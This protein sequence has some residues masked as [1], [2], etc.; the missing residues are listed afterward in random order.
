MRASGRSL[1]HIPRVVQY[2]F[3]GIFT[4]AGLGWERA[5][6]ETNPA[7]PPNI[8]L[9]TLCSVR[10]D[11]MSCYGYRRETTPSLDALAKESIVFENALSQWPL[12]V[13]FFASLITGK[14]PHTTGIVVRIHN[15]YLNDEHAT[16]AEIVLAK[17]YKTGA[18]ITTG[19]LYREGN[20]FQGCQTLQ[21]LP[22]Q[23]IR[24]TSLA[25][26]WLKARGK[27]PFFLWVHYNNAHYPYRGACAP[28]DHFVD[29]EFYD[30]SRRIAL[31]TKR[32]PLSLPPGHPR[33]LLRPVFGGVHPKAVLKKRPEELDHY[34]AQYD[35]GIFG[36]DRMMGLILEDLKTMGVLGNTV[37]AV[38]GDHGEGLGEHNYYFEHGRM[39]YNEC[40]RVPMI[41]RLPGG[42]GPQRIETP[43]A[44]FD[45][46]ATLLDVANIKP[47]TAMEAR[48]LMPIISG[49]EN[50]RL[51]FT[52]SGYQ[53]D[54]TVM[55]RDG[56][57]KLIHTR[58]EM[59]R[60]FQADSEYELY[61]LK[62]DPGELY[63]LYEG[64][65]E[66]AA[67]L[68]RVLK[69]WSDPWYAKL[70]S[71]TKKKVVSLD[72]QTLEELRSLGYLE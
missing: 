11:H 37:I 35:A 28:Q 58:N 14:Y 41:L 56:N 12:T 2:L 72:K 6:A 33:G 55:V 66:V 59:D 47:P 54:F 50:G 48:S 19:A 39:P 67:R 1:G 49:A 63:N 42:T 21:T 61:N 3:A 51:V 69:E 10:P 32:L 15:Q 43:V 16:L 23:Y 27:A 18:F 36:A 7:R 70:A 22:R 34:I 30:P 24:A 60:A 4:V 52:A 9:L 46:A 29:D 5:A 25:R 57:W 40:V 13:P 38:V 65:P 8:V 64:E 45:L 26:A 53:F 31:N 20:F 17:G 68:R 44:A 62:E 71:P